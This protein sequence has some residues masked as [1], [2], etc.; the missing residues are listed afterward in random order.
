MSYKLRKILSKTLYKNN[1]RPEEILDLYFIKSGK[2]FIIQVGGND[3]ISG[4]P[5]RKYLITPKDYKVIIF[6]PLN[7][8]FKKIYDLYKNRLD[9]EVI[10]KFVSEESNI[11][12][13]FYINPEICDEMDGDGPKNGW[14][15]GQGSVNKK[16]I[17]TQIE[18]NSFRGPRYRNNIQKYKNNIILQEVNTTKISSLLIPD[19][20]E[21]ILIIDSQGSELDVI[22]SIDFK[23]NKIDL[24]F[25]EDIS[26]DSKNSRTIRKILRQQ[27]YIAFGKLD[28]VNQVYKKVKI[29]NFINWFYI[30]IQRILNV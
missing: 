27:N 8:Y 22:L 4:D 17:E 23:I 19:C 24:I 10:N 13:M 9:V 7:Y 16:F 6:E 18:L 11:K 2:K 29:N 26:P 3:G 5:I 1:L 15:H 28:N 14:A 12:E 21:N 25:Y 20:T 30:N